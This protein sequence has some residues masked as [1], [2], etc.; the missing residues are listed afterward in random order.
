MQELVNRVAQSGLITIDLENYFPKNDIVTFDIKDYL[1]QGL[2]LKE[3]DFRAALKE[4][5]WGQYEHSIVLIQCTADAIVPVWAYMLISSLAAPYAQ[6]V[7]GMTQEEFLKYHYRSIIDSMPIKE[8]EGKRL[9][10]KGCSSKPVPPSAYADIQQ[11]LTGIAQ[12]VMYG[13]PCSTVPI[14]KQ[15]RLTTQQ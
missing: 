8:Y 13:E 6:G 3:K 9:V 7:Y 11:K 15:P 10:I 4:I 1:W 12:S 14:Y 5:D 2:I